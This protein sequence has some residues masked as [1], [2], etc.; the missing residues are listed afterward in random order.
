MTAELGVSAGCG[1]QRLRP[2]RRVDTSPLGFAE[3]SARG[4]SAEREQ[5]RRSPSSERRDT[6]RER[7]PE[8]ESRGRG[9]FDHTAGHG[10]PGGPGGH[11]YFQKPAMQCFH[12]DNPA[13][14]ATALAQCKFWHPRERCR[15]YPTCNQ[16]AE[17]CGF[18][19]PFC[20]VYC[21]C[22]GTRDAQKNHR[23]GPRDRSNNRAPERELP[24][25]SYLYLD[26]TEQ[27]HK[28]VLGGAEPNFRF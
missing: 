14:I 16:G 24:Y 28:Q 11:S 18:A 1:G 3:S 20:G 9:G 19:H 26:K 22:E 5:R 4:S 13:H 2:R 21:E 27:G 17:A 23:H 15:Y 25:G 8:L 6:S 12:W 7:T 10:G